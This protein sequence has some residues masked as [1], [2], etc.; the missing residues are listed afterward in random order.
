MKLSEVFSQLGRPVAYYPALARALDGVKNAVLLCQLWYFQEYF[1]GEFYK[2]LDELR[3]ATGLSEWELRSARECLIRA[4]LLIERHAKL[5][6]R[7]YFRIEVDAMDALWERFIHISPP[8][9]TSTPELRKPQL[10]ERENLNPVHITQTNTQTNTQIPRV[11]ARPKPVDAEAI[12]A[13]IAEFAPIMGEQEATDSVN[14]AL[15]HKAYHSWIDKRLGL[16]RWLQ[17]DAQNRTAWKGNGTNPAQRVSPE[18]Y[19]G[20]DKAIQN[21]RDRGL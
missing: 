3:E 4:D 21:L 7:V 6:H 13:L 16:R 18:P 15:N 1:G 2:S 5:E 17:R 12:N 20:H 11:T 8:E 19:P 10:A 9:E 14:A